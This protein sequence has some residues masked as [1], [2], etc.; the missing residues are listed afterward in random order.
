MHKQKKIK[1]LACKPYNN[2]NKQHLTM[3]KLA[4]QKNV[5]YLKFKNKLSNQVGLFMAKCSLFS[6]LYHLQFENFLEASAV[7]ETATV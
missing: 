1:V 7:F 3:Q 6:L 4:S 5:E 2:E